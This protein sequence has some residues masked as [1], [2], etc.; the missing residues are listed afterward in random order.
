MARINGW[1]GGEWDD[2]EPHDH[3]REVLEAD[4]A[5]DVLNRAAMLLND[6]IL[7]LASLSETEKIELRLATVV[8]LR[9][10]QQHFVACSKL[11]LQANELCQL[12]ITLQCNLLRKAQVKLHP[13]GSVATMEEYFAKLRVRKGAI[14]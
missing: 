2:S 6:Q 5:I 1:A 13:E 3:E 14:H 11:H 4:A 7:M 9:A 10:T 12:A 8:V